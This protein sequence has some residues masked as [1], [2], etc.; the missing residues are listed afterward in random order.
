MAALDALVTGFGPEQAA[1]VKAIEAVTN[2]DV[3]A[4]EY[5]IK[6]KLADN[7]EV[8]K[9]SEFVTPRVPRK[10]SPRAR[11]DAQDGAR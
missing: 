2:H 1:E 7:A 4:L 3:K 10:T 11:L 6:K 5:W 9:V 8:M